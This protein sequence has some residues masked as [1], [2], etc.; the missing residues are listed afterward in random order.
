MALEGMPSPDQ[1]K[2]V[3]RTQAVYVI[4][5]PHGTYPLLRPDEPRCPD[6]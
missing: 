5:E 3:K 2:P 6:S 1:L 4:G